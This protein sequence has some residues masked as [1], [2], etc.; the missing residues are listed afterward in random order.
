MTATR[1][2]EIPDILKEV[3]RIEVQSKRLVY[4][5]MSGSYRSAFRGAGIEFDEVR[6]YVEGDDPRSVDWNVTAR[7]GRPFVK[8]FVDERELTLLFAVDISPS[9]EGGFSRWS[10]R[11][12]AARLAACLA[13]S[14]VRNRDQTG[15]IAFAGGEAS[16]VPPGKG[17]PHAMRIIRD[18]LA[19][20]P[21][22]AG[23]G[24]A[25][26]LRF[27]TRVVRKRAVVFLVSDFLE[28]GYEATLLPCARRHDLIAVRLLPPEIELPRLPLVRT[29]GLESG[30]FQIRDWSDEAVRDGYGE[31]AAEW[32]GAFERTMRRAGIDRIDVSLPLR[33]DI[34]ALVRPVLRFFRM[35]ELRG[36][37][38]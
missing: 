28:D 24:I 38:R 37:K 9:M 29:L 23:D 21:Q 15:L 6:E 7:T 32:S 30:R 27:I 5:V 8:K 34:D 36:A 19:L 31:A 14:A 10:M 4:D 17:M 22:A 18:I 13:I 26:A 11:I 12:A 3:R 25:A 20:P 1:Q 35:R 33:A 16:Y 2:D